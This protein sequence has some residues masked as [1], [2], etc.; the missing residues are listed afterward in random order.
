MVSEKNEC[1]IRTDILLG[2]SYEG[3]HSIHNTWIKSRQ[4]LK[5]VLLLS[6]RK[7]MLTFSEAHAN[8]ADQ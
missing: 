1:H 6:E 4:Y 8:L 2:E 3:I 7:L 5:P